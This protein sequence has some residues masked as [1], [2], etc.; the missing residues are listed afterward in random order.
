MRMLLVSQAR[1]AD[2]VGIIEIVCLLSPGA[3]STQGEQSVQ[4]PADGIDPVMRNA[5]I[6]PLEN[7]GRAALAQEDQRI[8]KGLEP[9]LNP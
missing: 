2:D 1:P 5:V 8:G 3:V 6:I 4:L 9:A 7:T